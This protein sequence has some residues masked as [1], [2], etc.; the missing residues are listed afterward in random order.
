MRHEANGRALQSRLHKMH[1]PRRIALRFQSAPPSRHNCSPAAP[2]HA[3]RDVTRSVTSYQA[4][5]TTKEVSPYIHFTACSHP[6]SCLI[7]I[8]FLLKVGAVFPF[9]AGMWESGF[10]CPNSLFQFVTASWLLRGDNV[11]N[12]TYACVG[13]MNWKKTSSCAVIIKRF[14][15]HDI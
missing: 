9:I 14:Y 3:R 2:G 15:Y 12:N 6:Y 8:P 11:I 1:H 4:T 10:W 13:M 7:P 5:R